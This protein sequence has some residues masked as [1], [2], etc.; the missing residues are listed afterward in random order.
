MTVQAGQARRPTPLIRPLPASL[1]PARPE[2]AAWSVRQA[3]TA[4]SGTTRTLLLSCQQD[5]ALRPCRL[6][7]CHDD[8]PG[9][10]ERPRA[11]QAYRS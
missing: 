10:S 2:P 8:S 5:R 6:A 1:H 4:T 3:V 9:F 11:N 7:Y